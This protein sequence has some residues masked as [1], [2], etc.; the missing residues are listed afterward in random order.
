MIDN[1]KKCEFL[2]FCVQLYQQSPEFD[3]T[4]PNMHLVDHTYNC[5][6]DAHLRQYFQKPER[7]RRLIRN[8]FITADEKVGY[9][10][11]R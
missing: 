5:L 9:F 3:L 11:I 4:D 2:T 8:G 6:H 7:K 1:G 10:K